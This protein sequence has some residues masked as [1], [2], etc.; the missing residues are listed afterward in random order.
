ME[1]QSLFKFLLKQRRMDTDNN[2]GTEMRLE[3]LKYI[4]AI[5]DTGS[6]TLASQ[7]L[8]IAQPSLSQAVAALE[9]ELNVTLFN[10]YRTGAVPTQIGLQIISYARDVM[11]GVG[12]IEKL[13]ASDY[14][15][16]N[17]TVTVGVIPT[18]SAVLLPKMISKYRNTF[19]NVA[20]RIRE[21]GTEKTIKDCLRGEISLGLISIHGK[22]SFDSE[23]N[24]QYLMDGKLMAYV[25][26]NSSLANRKTVTFRELLPFQL[27]LYGDE[28]SLHRYCLEQISQYGQP[29]VMSTTHNPESIK[30]F[31]MQTEAVGFGP[32][33]SLVNDIYVKS[34]VIFPLEI[35][36]ASGIRFGILTNRKRKPDVAV[37]AFLK[38]I[39]VY[40]QASPKS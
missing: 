9:K 23:L 3:Q 38:E 7:R 22:R 15:K 24:F 34:G 18:L 30:R 19:P 4:I 17:S 39:L 21:Q 8:F 31:V 5:A 37:D 40:S 36:D 6:F 32:D 10:R 13:S 33:L 27:F 26:A 28:F 12:E 1:K 2:G 35:T 11:R 16:I 29:N 14:S 25:G 20:I